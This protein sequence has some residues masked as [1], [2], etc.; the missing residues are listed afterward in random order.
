MTD[1]ASKPEDLTA[2]LERLRL[3]STGGKSPSEVNEGQVEL[4]L[5]RIGFLAETLR[6]SGS[7]ATTSLANRLLLS[8]LAFVVAQFRGQTNGLS[9][10]LSRAVAEL[11]PAIEHADA[12]T[13]AE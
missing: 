6:G 5:A 2:L 1:P 11:G 4:L 12:Q 3:Q 9:A 7:S 13:K 10:S 8:D